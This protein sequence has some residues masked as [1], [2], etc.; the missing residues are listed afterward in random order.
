MANL[1]ADVVNERELNLK[2]QMIVS[3]TSR[4]AYW[5]SIYFFDFCK[6]FFPGATFVILVY[7]LGLG[8]PYVWLIVFLEIL[9]ILPCY[10]CLSFLFKTEMSSR[11]VLRYFEMLLGSIAAITVVFLLIFFPDTM[12]YV[13][14]VLMPYPGYCGCM[15]LFMG[16]IGK[17]IL[18]A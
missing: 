6:F 12:K 15:A 11:N 17:D 5:M 8:I 1:A 10:Y 3:G 4:F 7:A 18:S 2:H 9:S 14:W 16:V 13:R